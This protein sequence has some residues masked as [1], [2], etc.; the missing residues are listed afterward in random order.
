MKQNTKSPG[1]C[2]S[3]TPQ[4]K[5]QQR[6][7]RRGTLFKKAYEYSRDCDA[8]VYILLRIRKNSQVFVFDSCSDS[9]FP[10]SKQE[11]VWSSAKTFD[12]L[13][14]NMQKDTYYP[15]PKYTSNN[16]FARKFKS[17]KT[18]IAST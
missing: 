18:E 15:I 6:N 7:R 17:K 2:W 5:S 16:D 8:D 12:F 1:K 13:S 3:D 9:I 14:A 11:L 4:S 10:P